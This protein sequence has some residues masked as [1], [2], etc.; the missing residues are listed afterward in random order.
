MYITKI[1]ENTVQYKQQQHIMA[2]QKKDTKKKESQILLKHFNKP[3]NIKDNAIDNS[4][5]E[6]YNNSNQQ[7]A[8]CSDR[9]QDGRGREQKI[10]VNPNTL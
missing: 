8:N 3:N 6:C 2:M 1:K 9:K 10:K 4:F 7:Y 5:G